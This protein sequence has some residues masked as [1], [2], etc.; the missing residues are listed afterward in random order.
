LKSLLT[1]HP[2]REQKDYDAWPVPPQDSKRLIMPLCRKKAKKPPLPEVL[3]PR[4]MVSERS[5]EQGAINTL[6]RRLYGPL[7]EEG[8]VDSR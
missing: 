4:C 5:W 2:L 7:L 6:L 1:L 8:G 3:D